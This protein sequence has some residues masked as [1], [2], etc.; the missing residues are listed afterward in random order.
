MVRVTLEEWLGK[1]EAGVRAAADKYVEH[2][3]RYGIPKL[4]RYAGMFL[5]AHNAAPYIPVLRT[6][7]E[8]HR[9]VQLSWD[10]TRAVSAQYHGR[11]VTGIAA[12]IPAPAV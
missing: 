1:Y 7:T 8:R 11:G 3:I 10:T 4:R 5:A 6:D 2:A 9:N 12:A